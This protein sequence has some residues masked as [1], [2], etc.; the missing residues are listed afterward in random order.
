VCGAENVVVFDKAAAAAQMDEA[1]TTNDRRAVVYARN[2][3][4]QI[5]AEMGLDY[6]LQ[7]DDDY[8]WFRHSWLAP[9]EEKYPPPVPSDY[10]RSTFVKRMDDVVEAML[11]FLDDT[12]ADCVAFS[13]GGDHVGA[14]MTR[15]RRGLLRK[16]MN[17]LFLRTDRPVEFLGRINDD[18]NAYIV[19]GSRGALFL[20]VLGVQL[21]QGVTQHRPGGMSEVYLESGTYTKSFY[22]VMMA[23]SCITVRVLVTVGNRY[24]HKILWWNAVP[25]ILSE[26][27]RKVAA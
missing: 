11:T 20:T 16:A 6:L 7:L 21:N 5:A 19:H 8:N 24:H 23:P 9:G 26:R 14:G 22:S 4:Q 2:A 17:A 18:V 12:D 25:K 15:R 1:D 3:S 13:Q 27:H 10:V